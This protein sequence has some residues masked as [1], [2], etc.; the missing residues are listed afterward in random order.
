[1]TVTQLADDLGF[2]VDMSS[3][4]LKVLKDAGLNER[5]RNR[6]YTLTKAYQPVPGEPLLD[7]GHCVLRLD[8]AG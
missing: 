4:H 8:A 2:S 1:M 7:L 3:K 6:L 5:K